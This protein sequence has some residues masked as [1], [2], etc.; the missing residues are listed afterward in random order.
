MEPE[1]LKKL[2]KWAQEKIQKLLLH[3][4]HLRVL[5]NTL[6]KEHPESNTAAQIEGYPKYQVMYLPDSTR[7]LFKGKGVEV[8]VFVDLDGIVRVAIEDGIILPWARNVIYVTDRHNT[9][10]K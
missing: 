3:N 5:N 10:N 1:E 9:S 6:R 7:V 8:E 2:P 4:R